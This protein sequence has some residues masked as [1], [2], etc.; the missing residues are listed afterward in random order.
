MAHL[1]ASEPAAGCACAHRGAGG[2]TG[3]T[4]SAARGRF[5]GRFASDFVSALTL[6]V[7]LAAP[8]AMAETTDSPRD[9]D[10]LAASQP[11]PAE[12]SDDRVIARVTGVHGRVYAESPDGTRR[13]LVENGPIYPGDRLVTARGAQLGVLSGDHYTGLNEDT[14]LSYSLTPGG[15][16][17]VRLVRGQVRVLE[18]G[19]GGADAKLSTPELE[20]AA[21]SGDVEV[22]AFPE[23]AYLVSMVCALEGQVQAA[24]LAGQSA[25]VAE[26]GCAI[27]KPMEGIYAAG[28]AAPPLAPVGAAGPGAVS[29]ASAPPP[30]SGDAAKRFMSPDDV[31]GG[32]Q[33]FAA[34]QAPPFDPSSQVFTPCGGGLSAACG[35]AAVAPNPG[36]VGPFFPPQPPGLPT[37]PG[38]VGPFF[39][40]QPALP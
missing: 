32:A 36:P 21:A 29:P 9:F 1:H 34:N 26:G 8:V 18:A 3:G 19:E 5:P 27:A 16:P 35:A 17:E 24:S 13:P 23:K 2:K 6:I 37:N 39:P 12:A 22:Y 28:A 14:E 7:I 11:D 4:S 15:A 10:E 31:E 20:I 38:P 33:M 25:T 30:P 40:P